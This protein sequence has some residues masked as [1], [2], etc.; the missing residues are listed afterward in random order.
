MKIFSTTNLDVFNAIEHDLADT[1]L[2]YVEFDF[3]REVE[4][5]YTGGLN[6]QP[7]FHPQYPLAQL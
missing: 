3:I 2:T 5:E 7:I 4:L 6:F 1:G